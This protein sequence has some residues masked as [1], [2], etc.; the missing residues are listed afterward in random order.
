MFRD[1]GPTVPKESF[2]PRRKSEN[3]KECVIPAE[4]NQEAVTEL[5]ADGKE[6]VQPAPASRSKAKL[7]P[8]LCDITPAHTGLT[9]SYRLTPITRSNTPQRKTQAG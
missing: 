9:Q 1:R 2:Q 3:K 6:P 7:T 5:L 8:H 4:G